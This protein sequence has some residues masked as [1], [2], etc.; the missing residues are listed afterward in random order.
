ML[1]AVRKGGARQEEVGAG[2]IHGACLQRA[3]PGY[4][5]GRRQRD[6]I[7]A[8]FAA[9]FQPARRVGALAHARCA[10]GGAFVRR[11]QGDFGDVEGIEAGHRLQ[12][13]LVEARVAGPAAIGPHRVGGRAGVRVV[14]LRG[15]RLQQPLGRQSE[16]GLAALLPQAQEC[17]DGVGAKQILGSVDLCLQVGGFAHEGVVERFIVGAELVQNAAGD[18]G[19][20]QRIPRQDG[21]RPFARVDRRQLDIALPGCLRLRVRRRQQADVDATQMVRRIE[22]HARLCAQ[23]VRA[24][25]E[26]VKAPPVPVEPVR[27]PG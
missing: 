8:P 10:A 17:V 24:E 7:V 5:R 3:V 27:R 15:Q 11:V 23:P 19:N 26:R 20:R 25:E 12:H 14:Q 6:R 4:L 21:V 2:Q 9:V 22:R 18:Q 1:A 16:A 13:R